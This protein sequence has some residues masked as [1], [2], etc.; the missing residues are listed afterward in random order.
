MER[1]KIIVKKKPKKML[2]PFMPRPD[3]CD[4]G[5]GPIFNGVVCVDTVICEYLCARDCP[6][7]REYRS[8]GRGKK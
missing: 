8:Q 7:Y 4:R 2:E 6:A 1:K 3:Y 5:I